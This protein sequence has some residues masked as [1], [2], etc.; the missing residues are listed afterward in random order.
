VILA[1]A[2]ALLAAGCSAV[3]EARRVQDPASALPGERT[4]TAAELGLPTTGTLILDAALVAAL[5]AHPLV[6]QA[7]HFEEVAAART[8]QAEG[9]LLPSLSASASKQYRNQKPGGVP[10]GSEEH[11]FQSYGFQV[12]WLL[13]DFDKTPAY[14]RQAAEQW[15]AAQADVRGAEVDQAFNVRLAYFTLVKNLGLRS[16]AKDAVTQ[17]SEHLEQVKEFVRVGT[18]IPY[19]ATKAEVDLGNAQLDLVIAEDLVLASQAT[20]ATSIGLA[21]TTDW[22]PEASTPA[23]AVPETFDACWAEAK[24][25]RPA[26]AAAAARERAASELVNA[27]VASLYPSFDLGFL[28]NASGAT[29]PLNWNWQTGA[30]GSWVPFDGFQNLYSIEEAVANLRIARTDRAREEQRAWL[31]VRIAWIATEDARR[32]LDLTSLLV[33]N[34]EEGL[35]LEQG[36]FDVGRATTIE[37]TDARQAVTEA[38][39]DD[40]QARA[41]RDIANARLAQALG[42][43]AVGAAAP[44][45]AEK[46]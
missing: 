17:F 32:R 44:T 40:V 18:R 43:T 27:R 3:R 28:F 6:V 38:R 41:E 12:S 13:F 2:L 5:R 30:T 34:A 36:R 45:A 23:L 11:R 20:L 29:S 15:L 35:A 25:S 4:P 46:P 16:V 19:D 8:G 26:L 21:E 31:E 42:K 37:L 1:T 33:R 22:T 24:R 10:S 39:S 7:R 9:A 14:A